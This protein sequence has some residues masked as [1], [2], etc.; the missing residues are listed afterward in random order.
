MLE[1]DMNCVTSRVDFGE[2]LD[3]LDEFRVENDIRTLGARFAKL[4]HE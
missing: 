2:S 4:L 1:R 3:A